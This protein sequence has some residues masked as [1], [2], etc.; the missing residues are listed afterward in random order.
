[1]KRNLILTFALSGVFALSFQTASAQITIT[2]P[3][4]PKIKKDKQE[5]PKQ[6]QQTTQQ[7]E[8]QQSPTND[9]NQSNENTSNDNQR[10][11]NETKKSEQDFPS[12]YF[13]YPMWLKEIEAAVKEAEEYTPQ[14]DRAIYTYADRYD[15]GLIAVSKSARDDWFKDPEFAAWRKANPKNKFDAAFD[16]LAAILAKKMPAFK[17]GLANYKFRN[18]A[19]EKV[20]KTAFEDIT[21]YQIFS[22]GILES[23]WLIEKDN[24][25]F[26]TSRYKHAVF[27]L[28]DKKGDHPYCYLTFVNIIQDYA[29]GGT[30]A[31]SRARFIEDQLVGCPAGK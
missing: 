1:M 10:T 11:E 14:S 6:D 26:P 24:Y 4:I 17:G 5:Q 12:D 15:W 2:I 7:Q 28:K 31:A 19:D 8:S 23:N 30:Y 25:N 27:Y 9:T 3:K 16:K 20:L 13:I 18:P 29:G 22:Y 21:R